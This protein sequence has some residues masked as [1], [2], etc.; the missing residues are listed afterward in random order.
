MHPS[1]VDIIRCPICRSTQ[2][3]IHIEETDVREIRT[4]T[5]KCSSCHRSFPIENGVLDLLPDPND[6]ILR[7]QQGW[8]TLLGQPDP[9]IEEQMLALPYNLDPHW[10]PIAENF[11]Q[12]LRHADL[13]DKRVLDIGS[14]RT[15]SARR[16]AALGAHVVAT[17]VLR[18]K[19]IGLDTAD[20]FLAADNCYYE[21]VLCD[22]ENLPF[23]DGSFDYIFSSASLHHAL[24]LRAGF[25]ALHRVL[26]LGG[27]LLL[28]NEPVLRYGES[29]T[30]DGNPEV[31][32]GINE[33]IYAIDEWLT[34]AQETRFSSQLIFPASVLRAAR[35]QK[36]AE[37]ISA[38]QD[39]DFI[40]TLLAHPNLSWMDR[41]E[42]IARIYRC[43]SLPLVMRARAIDDYIPK[44][45]QPTA[46]DLFLSIA[47]TTRINSSSNTVNQLTAAPE[48]DENDAY[49]EENVA[50]MCATW[51][52]DPHRIVI[53]Q[54]P[55]LG[56]VLNAFQRIVRSATWW[57]ALPQ[58]SQIS[59][60]QGSVVRVTDSLLYKQR[61]LCE[62]LSRRIFM[63]VGWVQ[64]FEKQIALLQTKQEVLQSRIDLLEAQVAARQR[65]HNDK[66]SE[67]N[68]CK[69]GQ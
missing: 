13:R 58:W 52:V 68:F 37:I 55:R 48:L 41:T 36:L 4:G 59:E 15:W 67:D 31:A 9:N 7:E 28:V 27:E 32:A 42:S 54:Q 3:N 11:D 38:H 10:Q 22:M 8:K 50:G 45:W 17:D 65:V 35:E 29:H 33:H 2:L 16:M 24:D 69:E 5:V 47:T 66:E 51:S 39:K 19:Y 12:I 60:F 21:R 23:R 53:S 62:Q 1:L 6:A 44:V 25:S 18:L 43:Y 49:L 63:L 14:G 34:A 64:A 30:W 26:R 46:D 20:I 61:R 57:Y 56:G 40:Q